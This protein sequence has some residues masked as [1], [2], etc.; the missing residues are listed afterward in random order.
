MSYRFFESLFGGD[1]VSSEAFCNRMWLAVIQAAIGFDSRVFVC[2]GE[3]E[4][5]AGKSLC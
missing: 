1:R 3:D 2:F 4:S 5:Y